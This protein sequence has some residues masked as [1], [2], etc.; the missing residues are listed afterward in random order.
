MSINKLVSIKNAI[1]NALDYVGVDRTQDMPVLMNWAL[2]AEREIGHTSHDLT[3]QKV[4]LDVH[5]CTAELP[6]NAEILEFALFGSHDCSCN[7]LR[8][9]YLSFEKS[10]DSSGGATGGFDGGNFFV[11]DMSGDYCGW[12]NGLLYEIQNNKIVFHQ[13]LKHSHITIQ[14]LGL[15]L[16]DEGFAKVSENHL[17]AIRQYILWQYG[18]RSKYSANPMGIQNIELAKQEWFRLCK[19]ARADDKKLSPSEQSLLGNI[20]NNNP[21]NGHGLSIGMR[22]FGWYTNT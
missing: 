4:V 12:G 17:R 10:F 18:E 2:E 9:W 20:L 5:C 16:D 11:I 15:E 7:D 22:T 6:C 1:I 3:R 14:Y 19:H 8:D 21:Y 13:S